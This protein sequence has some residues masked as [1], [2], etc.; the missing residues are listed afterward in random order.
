[1]ITLRRI[2]TL[3]APIST[4][5]FELTTARSSMPM[6]EYRQVIAVGFV[7]GRWSIGPT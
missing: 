3:K 6:V 4:R 1:M 2:S 7:N 5:E